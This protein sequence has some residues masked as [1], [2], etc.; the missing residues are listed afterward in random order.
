[1]PIIRLRTSD[2]TTVGI[3]TEEEVIE[4]ISV[5]EEVVVLEVTVEEIKAEVNLHDTTR[6]LKNGIV[7]F[8]AKMLVIAPTSVFITN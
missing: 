3:G 7:Q 1:M 5:P 6:P 4:E 8:V 2:L